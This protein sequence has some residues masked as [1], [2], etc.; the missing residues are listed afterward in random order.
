MVA[1]VLCGD[2]EHESQGERSI[3]VAIQQYY[4]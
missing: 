2:N 3:L 4:D 1:D